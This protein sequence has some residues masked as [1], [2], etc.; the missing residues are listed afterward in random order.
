MKTRLFLI[1]I[2][3]ISFASGMNA[4]LYSGQYTQKGRGQSTYTG[5]YMDAKEM[6]FDIDIYNNYIVVN[7]TKVDYFCDIKTGKTTLTPGCLRKSYKMKMSDE[8]YVVYMF[9]SNYNM[10]ITYIYYN[11]ITDRISDMYLFPVTKGNT[12]SSSNTGGYSGSSPSF[13]TTG[14]TTTPSGTTGTTTTPSGTTIPRTKCP[15]CTN[16]RRVYEGDVSYSGTQ[17][18]YSTC[19]ECGLRYQSSSRT[20]RHGSCNTCHG[21][22]YLD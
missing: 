7:G 14:T 12:L 22:G 5:Q 16:G 6:L 15:N 3:V 11:T 10:E 19:P 20:H 18:R 1:F 9:D 13:G 4:Q 8:F 21:S 2:G 17:I